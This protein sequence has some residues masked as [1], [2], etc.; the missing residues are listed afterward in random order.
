MPAFPPA[1]ASLLIPGSLVRYL[2]EKYWDGD[3]IV[4]QKEGERECFRL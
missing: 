4:K 2:S 1:P 3:D